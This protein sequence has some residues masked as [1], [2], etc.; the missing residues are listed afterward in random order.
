[1]MLRYHDSQVSIHGGTSLADS[2]EII[3]RP[4]TD[5]SDKAVLMRH[6]RIQLGVLAIQWHWY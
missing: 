6:A 2:F 3:S 4:G 5:Q 1:M